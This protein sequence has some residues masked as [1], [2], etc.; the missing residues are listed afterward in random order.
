MSMGAM[1]DMMQRMM[2]QEPGGD[3]PGR[4]KGEGDVNNGGQQENGGDSDAA[5]S[6]QEGTVGG[7]SE[8]RTIPKGS[9]PAGK[10]LPPEFQKALDAYNKTARPAAP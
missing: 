6:N 9:G 4:Q 1:L 2:G 3:Q 8:A 7:P 5:N 10:D